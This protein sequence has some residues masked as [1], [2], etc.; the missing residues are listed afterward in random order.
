VQKCVWCGRCK[1]VFEEFNSY[2]FCLECHN[3]VKLEIREKIK[4]IEDFIATYKKRFYGKSPGDAVSMADQYLSSLNALEEMRHEI[5]MFKSDTSN[6]RASLNRIRSDSWKKYCFHRRKLLTDESNAALKSTAMRNAGSFSIHKNLPL[7]VFPRS[8]DHF[9][10]A[11]FIRTI[12]L[13]GTHHAKANFSRLRICDP[14]SLVP[15]SKENNI[16][17]VMHENKVIGNL[18]R[19][20]GDLEYILSDWRNDLDP[21]FAYI[22][23]FDENNGIIFID[24]GFYFS[25]QAAFRE[26]GHIDTKLTATHEPDSFWNC[27]RQQNLRSLL[28]DD[29]LIAT[30]NQS[31]GTYIVMDDKFREMGELNKSVSSQL[32][33]EREL[34]YP[35]IVVKEVQEDTK[36][37]ISV[38]LEVYVKQRKRLETNFKLPY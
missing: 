30:Y 15:S 18:F 9:E 27:L 10:L 24:I 20:K 28:S 12:P 16:I 7:L 22:S 14:V 6:L 31:T 23:S 35:Y 4:D 29:V 38:A 1:K 13:F 25:G 36:H 5:P 19:N 3:K 21:V 34:N 11:Y 26:S 8:V 17:F 32:W 2:G 37:N 33:L